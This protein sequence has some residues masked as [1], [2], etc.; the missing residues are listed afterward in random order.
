MTLHSDDAVR[1]LHEHQLGLA[2]EAAEMGIW[3]WDVRANVVTWDRRMEAIF[4]L[5]EGEFDGQFDSYTARLH[6]DD[7]ESTLAQVQ[8][9]VEA[10]SS[11]RVLHRVVWPDSSLHWIES[12]GRPLHTDGE[13]T[14][15]I[16]VTVD[17]TQRKVAE[18]AV[19]Q[20]AAIV[21]STSDAVLGETLTGL[22]TS[23]NPAAEK[24]F[25][26]TAE[27]AVGRPVTILCPPDLEDELF[28]A[29]NQVAAGD[30]I[31]HRETIRA[32]KDGSLIHVALS[33]S[34]VRGPGREVVGASVIARDITERKRT[35]QAA[36]RRAERVERLNELTAVLAAAETPEEVLDAIILHVRNASEASAAL[37]GL[38][39]DDRATIDLVRAEGY[40]TPLLAEWRSVPVGADLPIAAAVRLGAPV[41]HTAAQ[42]AE[43]YQDA[44]RLVQS[45]TV[46]VA[47]LPLQLENRPFGALGLTFDRD[48]A[49]DD[50]QRDF[51][52]DLAN[53]CA[54]ALSRARS[55]SREMAARARAEEVS[56]RLAFLSEAGAALA[57]SL[58]VE[59]TANTVASLA[60]PRLADWCSVTI[61]GRAGTIVARHPDPE[62]AEAVVTL[63]SATL[64]G[65]PASRPG[66]DDITSRRALLWPVVD[67]ADL[68]AGFDGE[69]RA[70]IERL[71]VRSMIVVPL[72]GRDKVVGA[73][74]LARSRAD[75]A[76][77]SDDLQ[78]AEELARRAATAIENARLFGEQRHIARTLQDNLLPRTLPDIPGLELG[79][80]YNAA[81][82]GTEVGGDFYDVFAL[83]D[84]QW[85]LVIG[86]VCGQG[87]DAAGVT[88]LARHTL[89][90][91]TT[92]DQLPSD[93][94]ARLNELL[95][96]H[97]IGRRFIT[98]ALAM[99]TI[100][101]DGVSLTI[102]QGGHPDPIVTRTDGTIE[103]VTESRGTVLG[104][105]AEPRLRSTTVRLREG[106]GL[107]LYTDG[108]TE[109][110]REG[111]QFGVARLCDVARASIDV[112]A[113]T[114]AQ[115]I[116][117]ASI[118]FSQLEVTPDDLAVF[119]ARCRPIT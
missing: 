25:G 20:L 18:D 97:D 93:V 62:L 90:A 51:L 73:L 49:F 108:V 33:L 85:A 113:D 35:E 47:V 31:P 10:N 74:T 107:V 55:F 114:M 102:S 26:Y 56:D 69:Q 66:W 39:A 65:S 101:D 17:V 67:P 82:H 44:A 103:L 12:V 37:I 61:S 63:T 110:R 48:M 91:I 52:G 104:V 105:L 84:D 78:L 77:T 32:R 119:T 13:L 70:M 58:D 21:E 112:D 30:T 117:E 118:A 46:A 7:R 16:G 76:Y 68:G 22:I 43:E 89:R 9:A 86:D 111:E 15:M 50:E 109:V 59:T 53:R 87:A 54:L 60:V 41:F 75:R 4:G 1:H 88:A 23:W 42:V 94:L 2:L 45:T 96:A 11:Y 80:R 19:N 71:Q 28:D 64:Q 83:A 38:L 81:G 36:K 72:A 8:R 5:D 57:A 14:G 79:S 99:A 3:R 29:L 6:P 92:S 116:V 34:P 106:D 40:P 100:D 95:L 98:V 115:N 27:E 24:L